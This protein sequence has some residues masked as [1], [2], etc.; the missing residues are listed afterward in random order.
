MRHHRYILSDTSSNST[1][2]AEKNTFCIGSM[3]NAFFRVGVDDRN[4]VV[5]CTTSIKYCVAVKDRVHSL[6]SILQQNFYCVLRDIYACRGNLSVRFKSGFERLVQ[7]AEK[8]KGKSKQQPCQSIYKSTLLK[9]VG[10]NYPF[11]ENT[12]CPSAGS[13]V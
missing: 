11:T 12:E 2:Y 6:S 3:L 7:I 8:G 13:V 10:Q 1:S 9:R 4:P 5:I